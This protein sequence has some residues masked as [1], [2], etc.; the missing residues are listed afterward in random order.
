M[1]LSISE[2]NKDFTYFHAK[3]QKQAHHIVSE[4]F[5][6]RVYT[7]GSVYVDLYWILTK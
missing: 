6:N 5:A 2:H 7:S 3:H 1:I 4:A